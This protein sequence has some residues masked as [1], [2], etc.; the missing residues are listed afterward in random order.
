MTG[1]FTTQLRVRGETHEYLAAQAKQAG[2]SITQAAGVILDYACRQGWEV[3]PVNGNPAA[4][5]RRDQ[6]GYRIAT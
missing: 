2:L 5:G 3:G 6:A 1:W 4:T